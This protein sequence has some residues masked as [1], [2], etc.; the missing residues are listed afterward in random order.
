ML[1]SLE[2]YWLMI[3][4]EKYLNNYYNNYDRLYIE[5]IYN[6]NEGKGNKMNYNK[7]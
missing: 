6:E 7:K 3:I 1:L 5:T 4:R 2:I